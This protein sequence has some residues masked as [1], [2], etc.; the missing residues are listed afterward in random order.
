MAPG[1]LSE[2]S[3]YSPHLAQIIAIGWNI[4]A[5]S[6]VSSNST[7]SVGCMKPLKNPVD[8]LKHSDA[9]DFCLLNSLQLIDR[10]P[11]FCARIVYY[12]GVKKER[13]E[14]I[15]YAKDRLP[16]SQR[17]IGYLRSEKWLVDYPPVLS[18][19]ATSVDNLSPFSYICPIGYRD[20]QPEYIHV[21]TSEPLSE[22]LQQHLQ[23][24]ATIVSKYL[25]LAMDW[26]SRTNE[27]QMLEQILQK[28]SHQLRN[29]LSLVALYAQNLCFGLKDSPWQEQAKVI[30]QSVERIDLNLHEIIDCSQGDCLRLTPQDLRSLVL[31]RIEVLQPA[32][33]QKQLNIK[34]SDTSVILMLDRSQIEQAFDNILSNAIHFS[35]IA[36]TIECTWQVFQGEVLIKITDRG[37]GISPTDLPNIFNPFYSRRAGGTGLGLTI[38]KKIVLDHQGS[39]WVQN[40]SSGGAQF[41]LILSR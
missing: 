24:S 11:I 2:S 8:S 25:N 31:A 16:F 34:I 5:S 32:I 35:P 22:S 21:L 14:A 38:A 40:L 36:G 27:I 30:C 26:N 10:Q 1:N 15:A 33:E 39:L 19:T 41:S 12:D 23:K 37:T 29:S 18:V 13:Q 9:K 20:L 4:L 17:S 6:C 3:P 7:V 28:A